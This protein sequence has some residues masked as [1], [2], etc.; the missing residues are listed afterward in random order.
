[1]AGLDGIIHRLHPGE[2]CDAPSA[3]LPTTCDDLAQALQALQTDHD[4]LLQGGVFTRDFIQ[5]Y[6]ALK[7]QALQRLRETI[8][9]MEFELYYS[10]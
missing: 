4:F 10:L 5:H 8:H 9:P 3:P 2:L 7:Q 1:M 6:R